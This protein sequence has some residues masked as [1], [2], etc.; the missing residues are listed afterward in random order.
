MRG[1]P[2]ALGIATKWCP[3]NGPKDFFYDHDKHRHRG[4]LRARV[5]V[6][7]DLFPVIEAL[8]AGCT[9]VIPSAGIGTGL[10]RLPEKAPMLYAFLDTALKGLAAKYGVVE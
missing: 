2:N 10:A 5:A 3:G 9:V 4:G 7:F 1:E 8:E 6:A